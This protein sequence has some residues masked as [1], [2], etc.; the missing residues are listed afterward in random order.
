MTTLLNIKI[1]ETYTHK[2]YGKVK[3]TKIEPNVHDRLT[4]GSY[5]VHFL[6][7]KYDLEDS[8]CIKQFKLALI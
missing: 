1:H 3:V 8:Q 4:C 6:D 2:Y 7:I 5:I